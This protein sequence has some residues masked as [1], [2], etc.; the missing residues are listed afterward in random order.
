MWKWIVNFEVKEFVISLIL[1]NCN[2]SFSMRSEIFILYV[3][4]YAIIKYCLEHEN[5]LWGSLHRALF[6]FKNFKLEGE[7]VICLSNIKIVSSRQDSIIQCTFTVYVL[8]P[9]LL[10]KHF[11]TGKLLWY[12]IQSFELFSIKIN[13]NIVFLLNDWISN[14]RFK[15]LFNVQNHFLLPLY[16]SSFILFRLSSFHWSFFTCIFS[17]SL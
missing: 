16:F 1:E 17:S 15:I 8:L 13:N 4:V 2:C 10:S 7:T 5:D 9:I 3:R 6:Q 12:N 14:W 11:I